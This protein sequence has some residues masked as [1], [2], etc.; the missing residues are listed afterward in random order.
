M[1]N[2]VRTL[3]TRQSLLPSSF[4]VRECSYVNVFFFFLACTF[5]PTPCFVAN[6]VL[7]DTVERIYHQDVF[8][9]QWVGL[10]LIRGEN[11]VLLGEIVSIKNPFPPS[12]RTARIRT[13]GA[14]FSQLFITLPCLLGS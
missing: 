6:L 13:A 7:E 5:L 10:F 1:I 9:E 12:S 2:L 3:A 14:I 11:V 8:A 4:C